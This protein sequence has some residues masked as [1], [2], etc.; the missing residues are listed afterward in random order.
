MEFTATPVDKHVGNRVRMTREFRGLNSARVAAVLEIS[1]NQLEEHESGALRF[2]ARDLLRLSRLLCVPS[3]FFFQDRNK[4]IAD[5]ERYLAN[6]PNVISF[7][8]HQ[9]RKG[10]A[11]A[12]THQT[13]LPT[14]RYFVPP[15][16]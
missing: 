13:Y 5:A 4:I 14:E 3:S 15:E 10:A 12:Q 7:R 16:L 1:V 9:N 11:E 2:A 8:Y 6:S